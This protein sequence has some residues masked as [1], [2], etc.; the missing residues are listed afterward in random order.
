M[1]CLLDGF[2]D[3]LIEPFMPNSSIVAFDVSILLRLARLDM[4]DRDV[5]LLR[6]FQKLATNVFRAVVDPVWS[7]VCH[8]IRWSD[9]SCGS[10]AQPVTRNRPQCQVLHGYNHPVRSKAGTPPIA[11]PIN[12]E[13]KVRDANSIDHVWLGVLGTDSSSGFS[14]ISRFRGL[15]RKLSSRSR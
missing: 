7:P 5:A 15:M 11:K 12:H 6:P 3:V 2:D 4:L 10:P 9:L 13:P 14:R 1:L 8:A